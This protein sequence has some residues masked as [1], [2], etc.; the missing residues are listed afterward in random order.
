MDNFLD[1]CIIIDNFNEKSKFHESAKNFIK[2]VKMFIISEFQKK[3]EIPFLLY[4]MKLRNKIIISKALMPN[5]NIPE[6]KKLTPRDKRVVKEILSDYVLRIKSVK[7]LFDL[8]QEVYFLEK[9]MNTFIK[10]NISRFVTPIEKINKILAMEIKNL[11]NN[12]QDS[13]VIASAIEEYQKTNLTLISGDKEDWKQKYITKACKKCS[14][15]KIPLV[16]FVQDF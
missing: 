16:K 2:N 11:N 5:K 8:K 10:N 14:Y 1:T 3:H 4:R 6:I 9:K 7:D 13:M 12:Y 15:K